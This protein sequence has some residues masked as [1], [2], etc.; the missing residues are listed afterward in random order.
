MAYVTYTQEQ[1][2]AYFNSRKLLKELIKQYKAGNSQFKNTIRT[3]HIA[4]SEHRALIRD[5]AG[6]KPKGTPETLPKTENKIREHKS[7]LAG[8]RAEIQ[9]YKCYLNDPGSKKLYIVVD[10][11][12]STSQKAVQAA[13]AAA[14]FQKMYPLAPWVNGTLILMTIKKEHLKSHWG[15]KPLDEICH[16]VFKTVWRESDMDNKVTAVAILNP[17]QDK[18]WYHQN[19]ELL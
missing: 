3:L 19:F 15:S 10:P 9:H 6:H 4:L 7:I 5:L 2:E 8:L 12:L 11:S 18:F 17:F 14:E 1:K 13:H 16:G